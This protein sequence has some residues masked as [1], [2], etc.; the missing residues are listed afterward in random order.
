MLVLSRKVDQGILIGENIII[1]VVAIEGNKVKIG[2]IA[3]QDIPIIREE[4]VEAVKKENLSAGQIDEKAIDWNIVK[5]R[6]EDQ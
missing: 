6:P 4:I 2:I 1:K 5:T 3:D